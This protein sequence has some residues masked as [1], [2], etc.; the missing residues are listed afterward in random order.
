MNQKP[1]ELFR[2]WWTRAREIESQPDAFCLA[3]IGQGTLVEGRPL[4]DARMLLLKDFT[5]SGEL[6]FFSS[7]QSRKGKQLSANR[8]AAAVFFWPTLGWQ[9]RV[10][11]EVFMVSDAD[12]LEYWRHRPRL[13]RFVTWVSQ[14]SEPWPSANKFCQWIGEA[15]FQIPWKRP[16][17]WW[18]GYALYVHTI[19]FLELK[20]ARA[21]FRTRYTRS[22][23]RED[24][25]GVEK[26]MP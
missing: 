12:A 19:E 21:S 6:I 7:C 4:P 2:R 23:A 24:G 15:L 20:P 11:G 18:V 8:S 1:I 22:I 13:S 26:L 9:V 3:T 17:Y 25:W 14:Q 10:Q 16:P 5:D